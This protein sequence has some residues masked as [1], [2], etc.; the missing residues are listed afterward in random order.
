MSIKVKGGAKGMK[1]KNSIPASRF[2]FKYHNSQVRI[3]KSLQ[4]AYLRIK[5]DVNAGTCQFSIRNQAHGMGRLIVELVREYKLSELSKGLDALYNKLP[6]ELVVYEP[7]VEF[8]TDA[9]ERELTS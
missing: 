4:I 9:V 7:Y 1:L 2:G 6:Y 8:L 5:Y 3:L